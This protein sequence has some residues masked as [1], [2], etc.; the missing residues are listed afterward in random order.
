MAGVA[1]LRATGLR[2]LGLGFS[3]SSGVG[4]GGFSGSGAAV[5]A[6]GGSGSGSGVCGSVW[7]EGTSTGGVVLAAFLL[8]AESS[9]ARQSAAAMRVRCGMRERS[10]AII[11]SAIL[12]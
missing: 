5:A 10:A 4:V 9:N 6:V 7:M 8:Q 1:G 12:F 3:A 2:G 11:F